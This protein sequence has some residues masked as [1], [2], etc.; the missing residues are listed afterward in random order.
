[1]MS[2][3]VEHFP[4]PRADLPATPLPGQTQPNDD[5]L[6][7][8]VSCVERHWSRRTVRCPLLNSCVDSTFTWGMQASPCLPMGHSRFQKETIDPL[9]NMVSAGTASGLAA[10]Q[11]LSIFG[12]TPAS[13]IIQRPAFS[14]QRV[15][16]SATET[17]GLR[18]RAQARPDI[19][20][21]LSLVTSTPRFRLRLGPVLVP[22]ELPGYKA[23][24]GARQ[25]PR[26]IGQYADA[27]LVGWEY[28]VFQRR[29][30]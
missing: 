20:G 23:V 6:A 19:V 25:K 2:P 11:R 7:S 21:D 8:A 16:R 3:T 10:S 26:A 4:W 28:R 13:R 27:E 29:R 24:E 1:M 12:S 5:S 18:I 9:E 22:K 15:Q 14:R 17:D 30:T